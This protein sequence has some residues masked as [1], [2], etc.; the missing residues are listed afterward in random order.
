MNA[1]PTRGSLRDYIA[2][3]AASIEQRAAPFEAWRTAR[4]TAGYWPYAKYLLDAPGPRMTLQHSDGERFT[5][6]NFAT[7]DYLSLSSHPA[8]REAAIEAIRRLGVHSAGSTALAGNVHEGLA[9]E[10]ALADWLRTEHV[11][12]FP[13]G[14]AAGYGVIK[15][16]V[17]A[18]DHVV[19][20]ELAHN[21]LQEGAMA[22]TRNV[23]RHRH[24]D[25]E[26]VREVLAAIRATDSTNLILVVTE[27]TFSMDADSPDLRRYQ[28]VCH[29]FGATLVVDVAHDLGNC[30]PNGTGQIGLQGMLGEIDIVMGS[31]S[32]TFASNGGFIATRSKAVKE[33]VRYCG[34]PS[35][36]SNAL[37][38]AQIAAVNTAVSIIRAP[39]GE[40][41]RDRLARAVG[42]LREELEAQFL[43][44]IGDPHA[45]VP[46]VVGAEVVGRRASRTVASE[47]VLVNLAEFPVVPIGRSRFRLQAMAAHD[48]ADCRTAAR[49]IAESI[50]RA[51]AELPPE[52]SAA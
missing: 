43:T 48:P 31:F 12:L 46:V 22:S 49:L 13:T 26:A 33:Y 15:G 47:G 35:I 40:A 37:S 10:A 36:F 4:E 16:L 9:L 19:L 52:V 27:G 28:A 42:A 38:P 21:C 2:T 6:F 7:Q 18:N 14:W 8:V 30:G 44:L 23:R 3:S 32:K 29:E 34:S 45:I 41:L 20:D 24:L 25:V 39:A 17:R 1:D 51:E 11:L 5:G 50:R